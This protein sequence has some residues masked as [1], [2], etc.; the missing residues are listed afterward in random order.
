[1]KW[2]IYAKNIS[3]S[4]EYAARQLALLD[5]AC[6]I[7]LCGESF[8][9]S[10]ED[11]ILAVGVM[12][13]Y[14]KSA[15]IK[16]RDDIL[17]KLKNNP[18]Y[19]SLD[20][21]SLAKFC[22]IP[23]EFA[24]Y[25]LGG[26]QKLCLSGMFEN[27]DLTVI[28]DDFSL[29]EKSL[30]QFIYPK[31]YKFKKIKCVSYLK[32]MGV[33]E[34]EISALCL[35]LSQG[36]VKL[37]YFTRYGDI[38]LSVLDFSQQDNIYLNGG[39]EDGEAKESSEGGQ[40]DLCAALCSALTKKYTK[41]IYCYQQLSLQ[42]AVIELLTIKK[43]TLSLAESV[44]GGLI[45]SALVEVPKASA[46]FSQSCVTY[47]NDAKMS[48]L[49][50]KNEVIDKFTAVSFETALQMAQGVLSSSKTDFALSITGY[51]QLENSLDFKGDLCYICIAGA[52][53]SA[54]VY[55]LN[56]RGERN[57]V[58]HILCNYAL[59]YLLKYLRTNN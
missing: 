14:P 1:M 29:C 54:V 42:Q 25:Y 47:S 21:F 5:T 3:R 32:L 22:K 31:I 35:S 27:C 10:D 40:S 20:E 45:A 37:K 18:H 43:K 58:R 7:R 33:K 38:T 30:S 36:D 53:S 6:E 59:F 57:E 13:Q 23:K 46:V 49:G 48:R 8:T 44:T 2:V 56:I 19:K 50:V 51:A 17:A 9:L 39:Q 4:V 24:A 34:E 26:E 16:T 41:E 55:P 12:P 15:Q 28:P 52:Q 11:Y